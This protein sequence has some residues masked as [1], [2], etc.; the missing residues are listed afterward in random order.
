MRNGGI[1]TLKV[2]KDNLENDDGDVGRGK[3]DS[4]KAGVE[5]SERG[6]GVWPVLKVKV[7]DR[8]M[9]L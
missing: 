1:E 5:P 6:I 8:K 4:S 9:E 3:D 2:S 7:D